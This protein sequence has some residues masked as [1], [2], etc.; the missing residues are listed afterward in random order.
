[1]SQSDGA[2][3][4]PTDKAMGIGGLSRG[5]VARKGPALQREHLQSAADL[6]KSLSDENRLRIL[7]CIS[8]GKQSVGGIAK[9]LSLSQPL[10]S[11]HLRELRRTLLV[12]IERNGAFVYYELSDPRTLDV[13]RMLGAIAKDSLS[14]RNTF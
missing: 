7:D 5:R 9:E 11:H 12:K 1:M 8:R 10:V 14:N 6:A 3:R 4:T 2:K 13:V